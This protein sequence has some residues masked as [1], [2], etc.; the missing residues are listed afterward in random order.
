MKHHQHTWNTRPQDFSGY[1]SAADMRDFQAKPRFD[2]PDFDA[3]SDYSGYPPARS[4]T[5][6]DLKWFED[7]FAIASEQERFQ[8]VDTQ[9]RQNPTA[10]RDMLSVLITSNVFAIEVR[11][12]ASW[13]W[14]GAINSHYWPDEKEVSDLAYQ[15]SDVLEDTNEDELESEFE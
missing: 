10:M 6:D 14:I 15:L 3:E 5:L 13:F 2:D 1:L 11:A 8:F 4:V 12:A 9:C 7:L